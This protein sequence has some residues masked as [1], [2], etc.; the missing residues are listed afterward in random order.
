VT[1]WLADTN[2]WLRSSE[3]NHPMFDQAKVAV[4]KVIARGDNIHLVPQVVTEYW[5]V[6]ISAASQRGGF[7]WDTARANAEIRALEVLYPVVRDTPDVFD[8]WRTLVVGADVR[9]ASVYD[10]RLAAAMLA[11]KWTHILT[12][13]V[14]DFQR[15]APWGVVPVHPSNV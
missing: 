1:D 6:S 13:N 15:Y 14:D 11:H 3:P 4:K 12:F 8:W 7:G 10:A 2:L 5:R 9:G